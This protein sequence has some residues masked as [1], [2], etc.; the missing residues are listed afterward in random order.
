MVLPPSVAS[1]STVVKERR[2]KEENGACF[3]LLI[4]IMSV[5][6]PVKGNKKFCHIC[7]NIQGNENR[8]VSIFT[9]PKKKLSSWQLI[10]PQVKQNSV[11]CERHFD[12]SDIV[13]GFTDGVSFHEYQRWRL[14]PAAVPKH[15]LGNIL[16]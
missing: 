6:N 5:S 1:P 15:F 7:G 3:T 2:R 9:I 11:L 4:A 8:N 13:K 14:S 10:I 16:T 12:P